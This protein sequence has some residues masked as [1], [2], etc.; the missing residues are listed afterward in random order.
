MVEANEESD[1]ISDRVKGALEFVKAHGGHI[2]TAPFGYMAVRGAPVEGGKYQ[3][4]SLVEH[5]EE[6]AII[7]RIV[8]SVE[9]R[10]ELDKRVHRYHGICNVIS[11]MLNEE[12]VTRRGLVWTPQAVKALYKKHKGVSTCAD[13]FD[14]TACE[15]CREKHSKRG[16]EMILCDGCDK[17]FHIKCI[18]KSSVP[19]GKFYCGVICQYASM[20]LGGK[21]KELEQS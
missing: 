20:A 16:N 4:L 15:V 1:V 6:F 18:G 7:K 11:D 14:E 5:P 12:N 10:T 21:G 8:Y 13:D 3:P 9:N 19:S 17:G 2:G